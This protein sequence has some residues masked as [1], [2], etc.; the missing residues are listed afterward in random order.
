MRGYG[1]LDLDVSLVPRYFDFVSELIIKYTFRVQTGLMCSIT[2]NIKE[3]NAI[4]ICYTY[5]ALSIKRM[6]FQIV[7]YS[8]FML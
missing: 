3:T 8:M 4:V 1:V 5:L 6:H 7:K 2:Q